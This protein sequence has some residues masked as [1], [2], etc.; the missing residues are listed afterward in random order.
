M[1]LEVQEKGNIIKYTCI[2]LKKR[3]YME[4]NIK[5]IYITTNEKDLKTSIEKIS[6]QIHNNHN[7][8]KSHK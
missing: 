1:E 6:L 5:I 2:A 7:S 4:R 3:N 8:K